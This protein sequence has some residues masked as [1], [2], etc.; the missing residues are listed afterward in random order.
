MRA[1][2]GVGEWFRSINL[3]RVLF[4]LHRLTALYLVA[5]VFSRPFLVIAHGSWEKALEFDMTPLGK[6]L[7]ILF[8][9]AI[10]FHGLNGIRIILVE[11]GLVRG[12]PV[13]DPVKPM[14]ALRVSKLHWLLIALI[15]VGTIIGAVAGT[16]L[17]IYGVGP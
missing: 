2:R 7:T 6:L 12:W 5:F 17:T 15:I 4:M 9:V 16:Y 11:L 8:I 3:E 13:R 1:G 14:P 10:V